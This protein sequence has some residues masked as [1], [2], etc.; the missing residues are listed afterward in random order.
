MHGGRFTLSVLVS[1]QVVSLYT[2]SSWFFKFK[3]VCDKHVIAEVIPGI[4]HFSDLHL[5]KLFCSM[6][7]VNTD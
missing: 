4:S 3:R 6:K 5:E 2:F 7:Q 1:T